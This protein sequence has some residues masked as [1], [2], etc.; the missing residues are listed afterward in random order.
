MAIKQAC[1]WLSFALPVFRKCLEPDVMGEKYPPELR[2][3]LKQRF[4][5][6]L[7]SAILV[8]CQHV[9]V[10]S[11]ELI[12]NRTRNMVIKV[13]RNRHGYSPA[14]QEIRLDSPCYGGAKSNR[15]AG[16]FVKS[17]VNGDTKL[18]YC[19]LVWFPGGSNPCA[20][21]RNRNGEGGV[22]LRHSSASLISSSI[23]FSIS[24]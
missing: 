9:N 4:V 16:F 8:R 7:G 6:F 2:G 21:I 12:A 19:L 14:D 22:F 17:T 15:G 1:K 11:A 13:E 5:C 18:Y 20:L 10:A 3:T 24:A 23:S